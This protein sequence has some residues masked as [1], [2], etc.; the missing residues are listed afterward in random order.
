MNEYV[1]HVD[2][3]EQGIDVEVFALSRKDAIR[4]VKKQVRLDSLPTAASF[5]VTE[6]DE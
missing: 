3:P 6:A 1:V 2:I 4:T 5:T